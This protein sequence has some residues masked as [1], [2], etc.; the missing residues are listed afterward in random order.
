MSP[1]AIS[2]I[3]QLLEEA[4]NV[5]P[6]AY[7]DFQEIFAKTNPT[8]DDWTALRNKVLSSNYAAYVPASD[9]KT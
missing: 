9:L 5:A 8:P 2:L 7:A 1:L 6:A 3:V 4:I